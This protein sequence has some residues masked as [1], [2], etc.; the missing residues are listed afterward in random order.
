MTVSPSASVAESV[1]WF[2]VAVSEIV[3]TV[4]LAVLQVGDVSTEIN[5]VAD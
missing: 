3:A 4:P 2:P 5:P 1:T